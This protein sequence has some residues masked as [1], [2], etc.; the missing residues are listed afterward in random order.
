[1]LI[2]DGTSKSVEVYNNEK[3]EVSIQ[4]VSGGTGNGNSVPE[5]G[6]TVELYVQLPQGLSPHDQNTFHP[7]FLL[8]IDESPWVSVPGLRFNIRGAEWSGAP[9]LQSRLKIS[10]A[11]PTGTE[12]NLWLKC[13]S[14]EFRE[15]GFTKAIQRH[16]SDYRRVNLKIS[17]YE[18]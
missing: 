8:N 2:L 4:K 3:H 17:R 9:N 18:K 13:E 1:M 16:S 14:Y 6:E 7:A 11:T 12:L 5:P 15:E 10:S